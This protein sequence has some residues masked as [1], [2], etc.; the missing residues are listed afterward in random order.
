MAILQS[1][2]YGAAGPSAELTNKINLGMGVSGLSIN[3]V[4]ILFLATLPD[5]TTSAYVFFFTSSTFLILCTVLAARFVRAYN[6]DQILKKKAMMLDKGPDLQN[7]QKPQKSRGA[8][9]LEVYR[10][11][12]KE[13][14][15]ITI[16]QG[17]QMAF[18]PGVMLKYQWGFIKDFSWFV[19]TLVTYASIC[20][21]IGRYI[22]GWRDFIPK[23]SFFA[24]AIIRGVFFVVIF[25]LMYEGVYVKVFGS[26]WF[27]IVA[28]GCFASTAG[29]WT[30]VGMKYGCDENTKDQGLAGTIMGFHLTLG[31]SLGS[32]VAIACLS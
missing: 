26:D 18:F 9:A 27:I 19:I 17:V 16:T 6:T 3:F 21:T 22:A 2:L 23:N 8:Q 24:S 13:A 14:L 28:L 10:I 32:A 25:M 4:R 31:I 29:Y 11:N 30:T 1:A 7:D 15:S 5:N 20:D 12:W